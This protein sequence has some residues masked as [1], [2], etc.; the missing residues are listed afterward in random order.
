M[1]RSIAIA[2]CDDDSIEI[3]RIEQALNYHLTKNHQISNFTIN[4]FTSPS[5]LLKYPYRFDVYFLDVNM[6]IMN[7]FE[8]GSELRLIYNNPLLIYLTTQLHQASKGYE[9]RAYRYLNKSTYESEL[10]FLI[11]D[12]L[13]ELF[14]PLFELEI[15]TIQGTRYI[16]KDQIIY[17][18]SDG[19]YSFISV[20][21]ESDPILCFQPLK[22]WKANLPQEQFIS[23]HRTILINI[24]HLHAEY[25]KKITL[26]NGHILTVAFRNNTNLIKAKNN[27]IRWIGRF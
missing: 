3:N 7:G 20:S 13:T 1:S 10:K 26:S 6:P 22:H 9:V 23:I 27:Y 4:K 24:I 15:I 17:I 14:P 2:L 12:L 18:K 21:N 19:K 8:L 25:G 16:P 5:S 11:D